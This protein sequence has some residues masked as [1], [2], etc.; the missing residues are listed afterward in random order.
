[1]KGRFFFIRC[2]E[3]LGG[4]KCEG[5]LEAVPGGVVKND[6]VGGGGKGG[7]TCVVLGAGFSSMVCIF[8]STCEFCFSRARGNQGD[9]T[10][11][12][13]HRSLKGRGGAH[14]P[15]GVWGNTRAQGVG[16]A[17]WVATTA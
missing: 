15:K 8:R 1:M 13:T 12:P 5:G 2:G 9:Q 17:L 6:T 7:V 14:M 3:Y 16:V 4:S 11:T 10:D